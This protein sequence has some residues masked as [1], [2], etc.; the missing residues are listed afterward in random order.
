MTGEQHIVRTAELVV[1]AQQG[2]DPTPAAI[3][4]ALEAAGLLRTTPLTVY[5]AEWDTE[6]LGLYTSREVAQGRCLL[7]AVDQQ[8]DAQMVWA[9][10]EEDAPDGEEY[11]SAD[12][13]NTEYY[14]VPI[15]LRRTAE[16]I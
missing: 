15:R 16:E 11:L 12:G 6:P 1:Q 3:V 9:P 2:Q 4:R 7:D 10:V 8:P 13:A 5:R 14:V